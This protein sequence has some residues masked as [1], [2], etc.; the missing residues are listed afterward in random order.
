MVE[1]LQE[2][3]KEFLGECNRKM[4]KPAD[5]YLFDINHTQEKLGNEQKIIV[6]RLV[7]K[8]L[9]ISKQYRPDIQVAITFL[10]SRVMNPNKDD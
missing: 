7:A 5:I 10:T 4:K 8:L 6:H 9:F 3:I 1:Y 2:A